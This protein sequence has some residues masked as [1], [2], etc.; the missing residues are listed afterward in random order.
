MSDNFEPCALPELPPIDPAPAAAPPQYMQDAVA[1]LMVQR[2]TRPAHR[3]FVS[4]SQWW[5]ETEFQIRLAAASA[6][7][8]VPVTIT[9]PSGVGKEIIAR[10]FAILGQPF[11]SLNMAALPPQLVTSTLFGH[12]KGSFTGATEN[13]PGAFLAAGMGTLFLDEIGE[14]PKDQQAMLLRVLQERTVTK[15]GDPKTE[16]PVA[17]R[18]V[19]ATNRD[20]EREY[21]FRPDLAARLMMLAINVPALLDPQRDGD[22]RVIGNFIGLS[23]DDMQTIATSTYFKE[24]V[25]KYNV[26]A[27]QRFYYRKQYMGKMS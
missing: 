8:D 7:M 19:C 10:K 13:M 14:L 22:M 3:E 18:I 12:I 4:V 27:L 5:L 9:G 15:V 24:L 6:P 21:E 11:V 1:A 26:R 16:Y 25:G 2:A 17:C 23:N 20:L